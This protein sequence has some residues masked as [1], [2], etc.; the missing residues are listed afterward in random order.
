[1]TPRD[2]KEDDWVTRSI[3]RS[4]ERMREKVAEI[5]ERGPSPAAEEARAILQEAEDRLLRR[6]KATTSTQEAIGATL[7]KVPRRRRIRV[8]NNDKQWL[9]EIGVRA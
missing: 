4:V 3:E 7:A 8:T 5:E 6:Q 1:M 2:A 9:R